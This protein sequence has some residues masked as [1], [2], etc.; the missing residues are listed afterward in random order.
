MKKTRTF[1]DIDLNFTPVP[2]AYTRYDVPVDNSLAVTI[3]GTSDS[4]II[5][6]ENTLFQ[7][8]LVVNDNLYVQPSVPF[9]I[10][11]TDVTD[12]SMYYQDSDVIGS[13]IQLGRVKSIGKIKS[14]DSPTQITLYNNCLK[15]FQLE[16]P[17][18]K[19]QYSTPGDIAV[20]FDENAIKAS[21]RHLILTM[22]HERPFNSKVGSQVK[23]IMFEL[24]SPMSAIMLKQSIINVIAA[25][26]PR[27]QIL[28][29]LVD[30]KQESYLV[31]IS[32]YFQVI[33]TTEPLQIDLVLTRTR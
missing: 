21:I 24:T 9:K 7:Y 18:D 14:I 2:S 17:R 29:V 1:S 27:V 13:K 19:F 22:N 25:Y 12:I 23:A 3:T 11:G 6:G 26:E 33:N 15:D 20:R 30:I 32:I 16:L 10:Q 8:M 4:P 5:T 28:E 31:N